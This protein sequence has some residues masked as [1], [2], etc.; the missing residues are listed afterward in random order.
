MIGMEREVEFE[1]IDL[2]IE[3]GWGKGREKGKRK[4][5]RGREKMKSTHPRRDKGD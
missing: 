3:Q 2:G 5:K 1:M 4:E